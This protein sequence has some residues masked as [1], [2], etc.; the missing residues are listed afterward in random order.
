M[1]R[2]SIVAFTRHIQTSVIEINLHKKITSRRTRC[3]GNGY[4][5]HGHRAITQRCSARCRPVRAPHSRFTHTC[6]I[7]LRCCSVGG[8]RATTSSAP[9]KMPPRTSR[10]SCDHGMSAVAN[11]SSGSSGGRSRSS[12][13]RVARSCGCA[14]CHHSCRC[15]RNRMAGADLPRCGPWG[16]TQPELSPVLK[17]YTLP[18]RYPSQ[19]TRRSGGRLPSHGEVLEGLV[20]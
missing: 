7:S 14:V 2:W 20:C 8:C 3:N 9:E 10:C 19:L 16:T 17:D 15:G 4:R 12:M 11:S 5:N 18:R 6:S 1:R 13:T